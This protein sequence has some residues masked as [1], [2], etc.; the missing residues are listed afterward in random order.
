MSAIHEQLRQIE[1]DVGAVVSTSDVVVFRVAAF[2]EELEQK[3]PE[4]GIVGAMDAVVEIML[5]QKPLIVDFFDL[6]DAEYVRLRNVLEGA[7][8][9]RGFHVYNLKE[10]RMFLVVSPDV[11]AHEWPS[12]GW[13]DRES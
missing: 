4:L 3:Y 10:E 8:Y 2:L 12:L 5:S 9:Y 6:G 13:R 11:R 1:Q 7:A